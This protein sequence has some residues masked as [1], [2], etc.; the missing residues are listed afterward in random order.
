MDTQHFS[1]CIELGF[2]EG[3]ETFDTF[4]NQ[5]LRNYLDEQAEESKD[6]VTIEGLDYLVSRE[7]NMNMSNRNAKSRMQGLFS[8]YHSLLS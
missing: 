7:L 3:D 6:A 4:T 8:D 5:Q 2:I 1:T